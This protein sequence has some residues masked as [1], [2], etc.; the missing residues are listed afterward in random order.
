[1]SRPGAGLEGTPLPARPVL[2]V[3]GE[4]TTPAG[5][6]RGLLG[7]AGGESLPGP[8]PALGALED[9][10]VDQGTCLLPPLVESSTE[11]FFIQVPGSG[12]K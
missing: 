4:E 12:G 1:M 8:H 9:F 7:P 2:A 6:G 11:I 5:G 10:C 3:T